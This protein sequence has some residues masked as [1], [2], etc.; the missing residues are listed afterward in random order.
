M[1]LGTARAQA[2]KLAE[3]GWASFAALEESDASQYAEMQGVV[4]PF[5]SIHA[6][7]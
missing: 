6:L 3:V 7:I 1:N 4:W 2:G 5:P